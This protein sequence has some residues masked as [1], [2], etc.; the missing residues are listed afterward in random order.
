MTDQNPYA[1]PDAVLDTGIDEP[2]QPAIFSFSGRIGRLRYLAYVVG[3]NALLMTVMLPIMGGAA[4]MGDESGMSIIVTVLVVVFYVAAFVLSV[5]FGK[6]RLNDLNRSGWWFLVFIIP[7]VNL[8]L[9]IY[10]LFFPGSSGSNNYGPPPVAN[11]LGI[12]L[13]AW[14]LPVV[15]IVG[16]VA[17]IGIPAYQQYVMSVQ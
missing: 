8:L 3:L 16:M 9:T 6:R 12:K 11:T 15:M 7:I 13:I 5:M 14:V 1:A 2:Y 17:A 4:F 10:V